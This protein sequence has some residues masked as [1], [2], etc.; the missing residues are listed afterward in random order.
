MSK[1][2]KKYCPECGI[3]LTNIDIKAH[4]LT[5]WP[6]SIPDLPIYA[7]ARKRQEELLKLGG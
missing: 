3:D 6:E 5:H 1:K 4:A 2:K 7:G